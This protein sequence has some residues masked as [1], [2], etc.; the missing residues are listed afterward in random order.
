MHVPHW[1]LSGGSAVLLVIAGGVFWAAW[2]TRAAA[3]ETFKAVAW[4]REQVE[5]ALV[6]MGSGE[7]EEIVS[8]LQI[9]RALAGAGDERVVT[10]LTD[11]TAHADQRVAAHARNALVEISKRC[12]APRQS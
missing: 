7:P 11:L 4:A 6:L 3:L 10:L 9:L 1:L 2:R 12:V 8:A 5:R